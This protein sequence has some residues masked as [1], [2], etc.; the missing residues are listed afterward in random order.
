M[1]FLVFNIVV[2]GALAYLFMADSSP[3]SNLFDGK[4]AADAKTVQVADQAPSTAD[5][6]PASQAIDTVVTEAKNEIGALTEAFGARFELKTTEL[7]AAAERGE[8]AAIQAEA[9]AEKVETLIARV[10]SLVT[11]AKKAAELAAASAEQAR[12]SQ[13]A[14]VTAAVAPSAVTEPTPVRE[15][16][17]ASAPVQPRPLVPAAQL[18]TREV[19]QLKPKAVD[20]AATVSVPTDTKPAEATVAAAPAVSKSA[21]GVTI[22]EGETLMSPRDRRRELNALARDMETVFLK[23]AVE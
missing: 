3:I 7:A 11:E 17:V 14:A 13:A 4:G 9:V 22:A 16:P 10:E 1:R 12:Q 6:L 23:H 20:Y 8:K 5:P 21:S 19:A 18:P 2:V 15:E